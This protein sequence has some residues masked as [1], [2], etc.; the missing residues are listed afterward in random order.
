MLLEYGAKLQRVYT[1]LW[2]RHYNQMKEKM[3]TFVAEKTLIA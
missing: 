3:F 1:R 2:L